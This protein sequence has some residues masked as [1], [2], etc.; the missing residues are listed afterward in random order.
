[1]ITYFIGDDGKE[2]KA[3][4]QQYE[5]GLYCIIDSDPKQQF[6]TPLEEKEFHK[7]LRKQYK[8]IPEKSSVL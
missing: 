7:K 6:G 1:M 8:Y 3:V 2:H 4:T 5:V